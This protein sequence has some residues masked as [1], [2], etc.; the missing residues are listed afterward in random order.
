MMILDQSNALA[1]SY[2]R[3]HIASVPP[4]GG[5]AGRRSISIN[6][7]FNTK[8]VMM[9]KESSSFMFAVSEVEFFTCSK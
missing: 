2:P 3:V 8:K 1:T 4:G 6:V 9:Y 5:P 7:N